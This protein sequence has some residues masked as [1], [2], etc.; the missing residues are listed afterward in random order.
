M[1][2]VLT[3]SHRRNGLSATMSAASELLEMAKRFGTF[4]RTDLKVIF[5]PTIKVSRT[6]KR[7]IGKR[8]D[9]VIPGNDLAETDIVFKRRREKDL[10]H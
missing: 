5:L 3:R 9:L 6:N 4:S 1:S 2:K 10:I 7:S 8:S